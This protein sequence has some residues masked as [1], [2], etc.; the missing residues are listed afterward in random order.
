VVRCDLPG[1]KLDDLELTVAS[2]VLT[3]KGEKKLPERNERSR[4]YREEIWAGRFQRTISLPGEV[5]A[6]KVT[7]DLADGVLA[8]ALPKREESKPRQITV[9]SK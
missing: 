3:L 2:G 1:V 7:A 9:K 6:E 4:V 5:D 8:V